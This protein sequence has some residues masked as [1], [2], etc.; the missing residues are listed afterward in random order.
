MKN[1]FLLIGVL[2]AFISVSFGE[3]SALVKAAKKEKE[4]RAKTEAKKTL[5]NQ[6]IEEIRKKQLGMESTSVPGDESAGDNKE[7]DKKD[8]KEADPTQTEE[9]WRSRKQET[10]QR[11]QEAQTRVQEIQSEINTLTTAFYAESDGVAQRP[12]IESERIERL[13]EL[14]QAKQDLESAKQE[15]E[16]LEDE[17]RKAGALP[18]WVRD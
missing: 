4:R 17:A 7:A 6:D 14:E 11:L 1:L 18:G 16:G 12:L 5:T 15:S 10:D 8:K 3:D 2:I 13:K 9:Y